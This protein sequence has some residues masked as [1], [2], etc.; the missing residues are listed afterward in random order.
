M[1]TKFKDEIALELLETLHQAAQTVQIETKKIQRLL[2]DLEENPF[3]ATMYRHALT[4]ATGKVTDAGVRMEYAS[5]SLSALMDKDDREYAER[6][7]KGE[8]KAIN[9]FA[10]AK[11]LI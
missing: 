2:K 1:D 3:N 8:R 7:A 5:N 6:A 10:Q 4:T 9:E 11:G